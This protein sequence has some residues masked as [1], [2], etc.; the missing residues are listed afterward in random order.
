MAEYRELNEGQRLVEVKVR[1][2]HGGYTQIYSAHSYEREDVKLS[3]HDHL[4]NVL[5]ETAALF[6]RF[7]PEDGR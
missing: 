1:A 4:R 3:S 6:L 5:L 7:D 2:K